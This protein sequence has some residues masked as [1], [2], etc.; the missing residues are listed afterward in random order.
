MHKEDHSRVEPSVPCVETAGSTA[1]KPPGVV[2]AEMK[3]SACERLAEF[4]NSANVKAQIGLRQQ[5]KFE[6]VAQMV[7]EHKGWSEIGRA[8]GW[9]G[10]AA[11]EW[12]AFELLMEYDK[13]SLLPDRKDT[14]GVE[15]AHT[16]C[17]EATVAHPTGMIPV[18]TVF[19]MLLK[20][21]NREDVIA[22]MHADYEALASPPFDALTPEKD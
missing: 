6:T 22:A 21:M 3:R 4:L 10:H 8:I 20:M 14:S 15:K 5:G 16:L 13:A 19:E 2:T 9:D 11:A 18:Q 7:R 17:V 12:F 1:E